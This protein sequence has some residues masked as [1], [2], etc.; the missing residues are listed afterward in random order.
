VLGCRCDWRTNSS[1]E[2]QAVGRW[3]NVNRRTLL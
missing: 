2:R 3:R 1:C